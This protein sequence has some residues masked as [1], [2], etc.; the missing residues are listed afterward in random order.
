MADYIDREML[1]KAVEDFYWTGKKTLRETIR[2]IPAAD[3]WEH[4]PDTNRAPG[5]KAAPAVKES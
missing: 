5:G 4:V 3:V 1:L 2:D